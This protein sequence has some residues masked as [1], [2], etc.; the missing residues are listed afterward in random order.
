M[1][2]AV[3]SLV[4]RMEL[5][6]SITFPSPKRSHRLLCLKLLDLCFT[7]GQL[8]QK[9]KE[10]VQEN[11]KREAAYIA[12]LYNK[13]KLALNTLR[14][15]QVSESD[16]TLSIAILTSNSAEIDDG[17]HEM[18]RELYKSSKDPYTRTIVRLLSE[19]KN[20]R[21]VLVEPDLS[22]RHKL[23]VALLYL[24]D[25][26][27]TDYI[28]GYTDMAI[29]AGF[30]DAVVFTGLTDSAMD[31]FQAYM[32]R[33]DDLQT[34]VLAMSFT[35]PLYVRD[36]R[37]MQWREEYRTQMNTWKLFFPR[38]RFDTQS[39][40]MAVS[41]DGRKLL[42]P[43]R[44]IT[45]RCVN[46]D[47]VNREPPTRSAASSLPAPPALNGVDLAQP[48]IL[49]HPISAVSCPRCGAHLPRC[50][51]CERWIGAPDPARHGSSWAASKRDPFGDAFVQCLTCTHVSHKSH[52]DEWFAE[53]RV[54][55]LQ[56]CEC[57]CRD[58]DGVG[59]A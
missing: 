43:D 44:Q 48:S 7:E 34:A 23:G 40:S 9:M 28:V 15:G 19:R 37:F 25:E 31:L 45:I 22:I 14:R 35:A 49:Y 56:D 11:S 54:C 32:T 38:V 2:N 8:G 20:W 59:R 42:R 13:P 27:L 5:P 12:M 52:A 21:S 33:T 4:K 24:N 47:E 17:W 1:I 36:P 3:Q 30:E 16:R 39:T 10:L 51:I 58:L 18:M 53:H 6:T 57:R 50:I 55:P 46:C 26:E 41:W 29:K